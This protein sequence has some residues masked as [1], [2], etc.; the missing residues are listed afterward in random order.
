MGLRL[1]VVLA[2]LVFV[3]CGGGGEKAAAPTP[4]PTPAPPCSPKMTA[5]AG[6]GA[7]ADVV[8][9]EPQLVTCLYAGERGRFRVTVDSLPQAWLRW[10]RAQVE[11][12]QTASEWANTPSQRARDVPGVG[13]GAFWVQA[14]RELIASDGQRLLT[15]RVLRPAAAAKARRAAIR[16]ARAGLGPVD[17]PKRTGP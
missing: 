12:I 1:V 5:A 11:R 7:H 6:P 15:V 17:I 9:S 3:G 8:S 2:A 16:V 4:K 13:G 14:P 10:E